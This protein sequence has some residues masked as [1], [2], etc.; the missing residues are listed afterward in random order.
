MK[1]DVDD[2]SK[3][4]C[5]WLSHADQR[6]PAVQERLRCKYQHYQRQKYCVAVLYSGQENLEELTAELLRYNRKQL[7]KN[8]MDSERKKPYALPR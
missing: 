6:N 2:Q 1:E 3:L 7:E 4:V 5:V 8:R